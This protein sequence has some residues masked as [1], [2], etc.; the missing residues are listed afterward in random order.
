M[1]LNSVVLQL[2]E[3]IKR[4]IESGI[5]VRQNYPKVTD[6]SVGDLKT[7]GVAL[8]DIPYADIYHDLEMNDQYHIKLPDGGLLL[9][10]Y[11]F[12]DAGLVKHRLGFFPS[13]V[14]PSVEESPEL[15]ERD[16]LYGDILLNKIVRFPVRFDYDPKNYKPLFH[17]KSH[18]TFGQFE[19]CRVPVSHPVLP[20]VFFKFI[21]M[22]FYHLIYKKNKNVF[23][24]RLAG[25]AGVGC[26][27]PGDAATYLSI[28]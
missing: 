6:C 2:N 18:V 10:Q 14:L 9:F 28:G 5:S 1:K 20:N 3:V 25:C 22:N 27:L 11:T 8:K 23:D 7:S 26:M 21:V 24:R 4:A 13:P 15:Y 16:E 17:P 19:N 12:D